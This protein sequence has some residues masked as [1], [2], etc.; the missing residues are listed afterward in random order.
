V[1]RADS[2]DESVEP[3]QQVLPSMDE[4]GVFYILEQTPVVT[5]DDLTD[6]SRVSTSRPASRW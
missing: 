4:E 2:A 5:G 1:G 3:R 6:A